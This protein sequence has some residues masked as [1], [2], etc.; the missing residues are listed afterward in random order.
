MT[1]P[2]AP[3]YDPGVPLTVGPVTTSLPQLLLQ[4]AA[5]SPQAPALA[6]F[7]RTTTYGEL[8]TRTA[9]LAGALYRLGLAPGERLGIFLPNCP[10]LVMAY[11]AALRLGAVAVMLNPLLSPKELAHQLADSGARQLV[12]L[13][14]FLPRLE[15][16]RQQLDLDHIIITGLAEALP[17]PLRWLYP[18]KA[19]REG[20]ATGFQ[21][22]PNRHAFRELVKHRTPADPAPAGTRGPGGPAIYRRHHRHPQ[23]GQ[24]N[25]RQPHGQRGPDQR[26]A[27]PGKVRRRTPR[28]PAPLFPLL[29]AHRLSQLAH[30]PGGHDHRLAPL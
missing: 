27:A 6:F 24:V 20:L 21:P 30:V 28:G 10:Q 8:N 12:I 11:H 17:W 18:L 7:G 15:E 14:H 4:A 19:W 5:Q 26:L 25:P 23:G 16:I 29:R 13:D 22:A 9:G 2:W 1:L 3:H